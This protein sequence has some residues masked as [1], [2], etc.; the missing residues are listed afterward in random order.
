MPAPT[1]AASRAGA[2]SV[3]GGSRSGRRRACA[4]RAPRSGW[5]GVLR[6][7]QGRR[8]E[9][10]DVMSRS[11]SSN[12][13]QLVA[14]E[15]LVNSIAVAAGISKSDADSAVNAFVD[16]VTKSVA[17]GERVQIPGLGTFE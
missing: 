13:E 17:S 1:G 11:H 12:K 4:T 10:P 6:H 3:R 2:P 14:K 16:A 5:A 15:D 8:V 7:V 9:N